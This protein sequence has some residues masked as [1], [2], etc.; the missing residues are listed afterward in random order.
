RFS[1]TPIDPNDPKVATSLRADLGSFNPL[2]GRAYTEI[3]AESRSQHKSQGFGSAERRGTTINYFDQLD[4]APAA[5]ELFEGIDVSWSRYPGGDAVGKVLQQAAD[6]FDLK[7]TVSVINRSDYPFTLQT[8]G[9][10]YGDPS[11][12]VGKRLANNVSLKTDINIKLPADT[13][14]SQ[15]YWLRKAPLK[16]SFVVDDQELIGRPE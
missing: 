16:G 3:A 9:S 14:V 7:V 11:M 12:A 4:G 15:P 13:P 1:F 8:V 5:K 2:L 10:R 6:T